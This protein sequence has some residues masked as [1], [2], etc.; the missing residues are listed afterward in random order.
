LTLNLPVIA[1][2]DSE[3]EAFDRLRKANWQERFVD[4]GTGDWRENW[5]LDGIKAKVSNDEQKMTIDTSDGYAVLWTKPE[6]TGDVKIEYE[7]RRADEA[8]QRQAVNIIYV[9]ARG[10]GQGRC[11]ADIS[12]WSD[13]RKLAAMSD[14]FLNMHTYHISYATSEKNDDYMRARRYLPLT[15]KRLK[16]TKLEGEYTKV[17]LFKDKQWIKITLIKRDK[18]MWMELKHPDRTHLCYFKNTD[19][20]GIEAGRIG[21]R[22]MPGRESHFKN[23]RISQLA[24]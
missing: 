14:Y 7:F 19:K 2:S 6:F 4:G 21:L 13:M 8:Y 10:D 18:E 24:K 23:F 16:G 5:F 22:L 12:K 15:N 11:E 1:A 9:Q 3:A 17:G 20:P